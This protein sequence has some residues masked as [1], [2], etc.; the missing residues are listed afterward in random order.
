MWVLAVLLAAVFSVLP[1]VALVLAIRALTLAKRRP[2]DDLERRVSEL[3]IQAGVLRRTVKTLTAAGRVPRAEAAA[4]APEVAPPSTPPRETSAPGAEASTELPA[5]PAPPP[6]SP[7]VAPPAVERAPAGPPPSAPSLEERIGARWA[8]WVG[9]VALLFAAAFFLQWSIKNE[10]IGPRTQVVLGLLAG[11]GLLVAGLAIRRR[12]LPYLSAGLSGGGLAILYL[13]LW[14]AFARYEFIGAGTAFA[15]MFLVTV[16]GSIVAVVSDRQPVAVLAVL[17]GL[18]TPILVS[19]GEVRE[20]IL[21]GYLVVLELLVLGV[22]RFRSWPGLNRLAWLGMV[23]LVAP[24]ISEQPDAPQPFGRL[25]LLTVLFLLFLW[26]PLARAWAERAPV[27]RL[28]LGLVLGNAVAYFSAVYATLEPWRP[29]LEAPWALVLG[30]VYTVVAVRFQERVP[31]DRA[32]YALHLATGAVLLTLSIPLALDGPWVTLAWGAQGVAFVWVAR[33]VRTPVAP[34]GALAVLCMAAV[35]VV[36][37]DLLWYPVD[38]AVWNL[39]FLVHLAV[40]GCFV[41]AGWLV[42]EIGDDAKSWAGLTGEDLRGFLWIVGAAVLAVLLWREPTGMWP[43]VLLILEMVA[44]AALVSI[45]ESR[46]LVMATGGLAV[47]VVAR[48]L[49][50]DDALAREAAESL[51]NLPLLVRIAACA[52]FAVAGNL[53]AR[54]RTVTGAWLMARALPAVAGV[55]LLVVLSAGWVHH[56]LWVMR[57][58]IRTDSVEAGD[59]VELRMQVGLS[60]LWTLYAA[61][62]V[63]WGFVRAVPPV[64]YAALG[65]FGIVILKVFLVDM[66]ELEAVYRIASFFVL[67]LV[68]L[69]VS[70]FYQ[71]LIRSR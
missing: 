39:T 3:E 62:A 4:P 63:A 41:W 65:L 1:I 24:V 28:D 56:E 45:V 5:E 52:A 54:A 27:K 13:S 70:Y 38:T 33:Q 37:L 22:A 7:P 32:T 35:R 44:L 17:G 68:L 46:A 9:V 51:V 30:A 48:V 20:L 53:L 59:R 49:G 21:L 60:V 6:P 69:A 29:V 23:L 71:R 26:V 16:A 2:P 15:A 50:E 61:V 42:A 64:R 34:W 47:V 19:T 55:L 66:A 11:V 18:L 31:G 10:I 58:V 43:A 12:A 67:G 36:G 25:A 40:V 8:T 57:D 14:A